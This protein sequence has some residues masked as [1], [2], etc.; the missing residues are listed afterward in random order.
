MRWFKKKSLMVFIVLFLILIIANFVIG[1]DKGSLVEGDGTD[2]NPYRWANGPI[3]V[4]N[5]C[6]V[7]KY[8]VVWIPSV[9]HE[10]M[11]TFNDPFKAPG[12]VRG[13]VC[14]AENNI[15]YIVYWD[16]VNNLWSTDF[17][18][19]QRGE[20]EAS[21][22]L[23]III[24]DGE[25]AVAAK[26]CTSATRCNEIDAVWEKIRG[27]LTG[28]RTTKIY[29]LVNGW[30]DTPEPTIISLKDIQIP[31]KVQP[32]IL[33]RDIKKDLIEIGFVVDNQVS[34]SRGTQELFDA[35]RVF[36]QR[37][38]TLGFRKN[39]IITSLKR[40]SGVTFSLHKTGNAADIH[41]NTLTL[42][43]RL[44]LIRAAIESGFGELFT[45]SYA[46]S[47]GLT[48]NENQKL[49]CFW[50]KDHGNHLHIALENKEQDWEKCILKS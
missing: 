20:S 27:S 14:E 42:E 7:R 32:G 35:F 5:D 8:F 36:K 6:S 17:N 29:D 34:N 25:E 46:G 48:S 19:I 24:E 26:K 31:A 39:I 38:T 3:G 22:L 16:S 2:D 28:D 23:E 44:I 47:K 49:K 9:G 10:G 45:G 21:K 33:S 12:D 43:E 1:L 13:L 40:D 50:L 37:A 30:G 11:G 4:T 18:P 15:V 41:T